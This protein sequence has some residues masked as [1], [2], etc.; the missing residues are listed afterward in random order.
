VAHE[1]RTPLNVL[2]IN[3][4]RIGRLVQQGGPALDR[5]PEVVKT[6]EQEI[7]R[8]N[9]LL[10]EHLLAQVRQR[11][12]ELD[13]HDLNDLVVDSIRFMEPEADRQGVQL[14][15]VLEANLPPV[16]ADAVKLRQVL[17]NILLN[18][19]Q[20]LRT[21]GRIEVTTQRSEDQAEVSIRDNGPGIADSLEGDLDQVFR[22]FVTT[23]EDGTGLGL[24]ICSRLVRAMDGTISVS[25]KR[26]E[27][28]CFTIRLPVDSRES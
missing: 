25:S 27:G 20:A 10:E 3:A 23:K 8:I 19:I 12:L 13:P 26:G 14:I 6:L 21:G 16:R 7:Q 4:Q 22:P 9:A 2:S 18:A 1:V 11:P 15:P 5:L 28:A 24:S 17:L